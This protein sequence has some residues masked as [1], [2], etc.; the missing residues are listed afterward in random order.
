MSHVSSI[1]VQSWSRTH[2]ILTVTADWQCS[3]E[4]MLNKSEKVPLDVGLTERKVSIG[5][6]G[7]YKE[8]GEKNLVCNP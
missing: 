2:A 6:T 8:T 1:K 4:I 3:L 5:L 7:G